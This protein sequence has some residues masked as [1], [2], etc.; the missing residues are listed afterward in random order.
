MTAQ[1]PFWDPTLP[2]QQP[3]K[4]CPSPTRNPAQALCFV[5]DNFAQI[6]ITRWNSVSFYS[7]LQASLTKRMSNGLQVQANYTWSKSIDTNSL[8]FSSG[9]TLTGIVPTYAEN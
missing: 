3:G 9:G 5:N 2:A 7:G 8:A 4:P 6:Y 1:G